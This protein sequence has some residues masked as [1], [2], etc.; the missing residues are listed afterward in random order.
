[1]YSFAEMGRTMKIFMKRAVVSV[2]VMA[3]CV[4]GI[5]YQ[6]Q[7]TKAADNYQTLFTDTLTDVEAGIKAGDSFVVPSKG[8]L[9]IGVMGEAKCAFTY[10]LVS[11]SGVVV[12]SGTVTSTDAGWEVEDGVVMYEI[13]ADVEAGTHSIELIFAE[14][15]EMI[16]LVGLLF[17]SGIPTNP[18]QTTAPIQSTTPKPNQSSAPTSPEP[19]QS[20]QPT[21]PKPNQ[22]NQPT[23]PEP[24]QSNQPTTPAPTDSN[25]PTKPAPTGLSQ[26]T[27]PVQIPALDSKNLTITAGF[28]DKL[29]VVNAGGAKL[30]YTSSNI[31]VATVDANGNITAKKKGTS[32]ITVKTST[33]YTGTCK[34]TVKDNVYSTSK[35]SLGKVPGGSFMVDVY[36]VSYDKKGNLVI[37]T[38]MLNKNG[39]K[40]K[41]LKN[42]KITIKNE[43]GKKI[44]VYSVKKK[45]INLKSGKAKAYTFKI[46]KSKLKI[47]AKQDLR[48]MS[49]PRVSG[50]Y[51]YSF[52]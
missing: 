13:S 6:K 51:Y 8:A 47:K 37:K 52:R 50:K 48:N 49:I 38:R 20:N 35:L 3:L 10:Q 27:A 33:G 39:R 43:K 23:S 2:L 24:N 25:Q 30:T 42:F 19:N 9:N 26:P 5:S 32:I 15:Q 21:S 7:T 17:A 45:T 46:K 36:K 14:N 12:T 28:K 31:K 40:A 11:G 41:Y 18:S 1:M 44:G 22:S 16:V 34:V 29:S 4:G